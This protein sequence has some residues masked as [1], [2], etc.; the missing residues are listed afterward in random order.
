MKEKIQ[1]ILARSIKN[2]IETRLTRAGV[3]IPLFIKDGEYHI[4]L[5]KRTDRVKYHKSE[6]SFPGGVYEP[7]DGGLM[8]TALRETFEEI[9]VLPSDIEILGE[10]DDLATISNYAITPYVGIIPYPYSFKLSKFEIEK[11]IEVPIRA[12]LDKNNVSKELL[13]YNGNPFVSPVYD[14]EENRIWGATARI[15]NQFLNLIAHLYHEKSLKMNLE[16]NRIRE[17]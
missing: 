5:T 17:V 15:L 10:V 13:D 7:G 3:L 12:L 6:I 9:G 16:F 4:L 1:E 2:K 14:F 8:N 11:L